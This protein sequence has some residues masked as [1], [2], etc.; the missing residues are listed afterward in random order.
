M[1]ESCGD[2]EGQH[3]AAHR[4]EPRKADPRR[5]T[6]MA[7]ERGEPGIALQQGPV[8]DGARFGPSAPKTGG[9]DIDQL[10]VECP[11]GL[12]AEPQPLHDAGREILDQHIRFGGQRPGDGDGLLLLQVEDDAALG[13]AQDRV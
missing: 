9:R 2:N 6:G 11:Q 8:G 7:V 4:V 3:Q 13:L 10:G 5:N 12:G 1:P